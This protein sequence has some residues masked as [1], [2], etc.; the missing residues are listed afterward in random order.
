[1]NTHLVPGMMALTSP[2]SS[3]PPEHVL[4][5]LAREGLDGPVDVNGIWVAAWGLGDDRPRPGQP[6][7][8]SSTNRSDD[9]PVP[10]ADIARWLGDG[11]LVS[12]GRMLPPFAAVGLAPGGI[13]IAADQLGFRQLF[14]SGGPGWCAVSTS[15]RLLSRLRG[16]GLDRQGLLVQSQLG[17]QLGERTLFRGV[18]KLAPGES[19]LLDR[20]GLHSQSVPPETPE[21]GSLTS[22][23][24]VAAATELLRDFME[25]YVDDTP[26]PTLQLTGGQDSRILLSA[27]PRG[28]RRDVRAITLDTAGSRDAPTAA[29]LAAGQG[30]LHTVAT[31]EGLAEVSPAEW[32]ARVRTEAIRHDCMVDPISRA[33]MDKAEEAFEQGE[34]ISGLGGEMARGFYYTGWVRP[35]SITGRR[36]AALAKWRMLANESVEAASLTPNL[37]EDALPVSLEV[38][39]AV[40]RDAGPEWYAATDTLYGRHRMPRWAGLCETAVTFRRTLTNPMLD[41][42]FLRIARSLSLEDKKGSRFLARLQVSLD[43]EL[44]SIPLESRPAPRA[45]AT[46]GPLNRARRLAAHS[47]TVTRKLR[48]RASGSRR[49][50]PGGAVVAEKLAEHF[51]RN[52][53]VLDPVR[54]LGVFDDTWLQRVTAGDVR[55][56]PSSLAL[57]TN[58]LAATSRED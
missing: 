43:E 48:Q 19:M 2:G 46:S 32:F 1:M 45:Y 7:L 9:G 28:R 8:L 13:R 40:L 27:I 31:L 49:P 21:P 35:K 18:S 52:P 12:L 56:A 15:A 11:D 34:R 30:M 39:E 51:R 44:A 25:R 5:A 26:D 4:S 36:V 47:G 20:D 50:P 55:P 54:G 42:R 33:V 17:W 29:G 16:G 38:I 22:G 23:R 57:L 3:A 41:H 6:L 10:A 14:R 53:E 37:R 58:V 24:A